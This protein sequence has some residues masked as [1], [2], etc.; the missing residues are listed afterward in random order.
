MDVSRQTLTGATTKKHLGSEIAEEQ[1]LELKVP[2]DNMDQLCEDIVDTP[3]ETSKTGPLKDRTDPLRNTPKEM[4]P[5]VD[6]VEMT[7]NSP[8]ETNAPHKVEIFNKTVRIEHQ[9]DMEAQAPGSQTNKPGLKV[10]K[11]CCNCSE[12]GHFLETCPKNKHKALN[13][14]IAQLY[15]MGQNNNRNEDVDWVK[16]ANMEQ[17]VESFQSQ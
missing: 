9:D 2:Q 5:V 11:I 1:V 15:H 6:D 12:K 7:E 17:L 10:W 14:N 16:G 8:K 13:L 4:D 3:F